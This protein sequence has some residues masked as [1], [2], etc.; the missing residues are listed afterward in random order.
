L[1]SEIIT[2]GKIILKHV[3]FNDEISEKMKHQ[4]SNFWND[5]LKSKNKSIYNDQVL[6]FVRI[7]QN[8]PVE[9]EVSYTDYKNIIVDREFLNSSLNISQVGVSGL[10]FN[11]NGSDSQ[12]LF[13]KRSSTVTE[14]PNFYELVPSGN[15]DKS[16]LSNDGTINYTAKILQ[17]FEEETGLSSSTIQNIIPFCF[18]RD[19]KNHVFDACCILKMNID[20][21]ILIDSFKTISEFNSPCF[22]LLENLKSFVNK[23][24]SKIVPTSK[25]I[26]ECFLQNYK[27]NAW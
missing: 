8:N 9:I 5:F 23:N 25:A 26:I 6:R 22:I 21:K 10:I 7:N 16:V 20:P 4:I 13:A 12:I 1:D 2:I 11:K 24:E 17:E 14:Y 18:V 19:N 27:D 3:K 15:L